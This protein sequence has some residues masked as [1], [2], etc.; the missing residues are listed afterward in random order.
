MPIKPVTRSTSLAQQGFTLVEMVVF[1]V[2]IAVALGALLAVYNQSVTN[3]VDP[4]VRIKLLE[5]A[6]SQ[7]DEVTARK[8]DENTP[9]GG[10]PACD[11]AEL[12]APACVAQADADL[13][14]DGETG[15]ASFDDVDDFDGLHVDLASNYDIDVEVIF[16]GGELGLANN[17]AKRI[18]VTATAPGGESLTLSSYRTNF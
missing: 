6:Q 5:I 18:T 15:T 3:S 14:P 13:G 8:Y 9:T 4:I 2:V 12:N 17:S 10:I 7:L 16:A 11:S 1:M